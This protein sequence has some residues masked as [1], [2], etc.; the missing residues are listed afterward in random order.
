M[1]ATRD[2]FEGIFPGGTASWGEFAST[3]ALVEVT[4]SAADS[5]TPPGERRILA[6]AKDDVII[7]YVPNNPKVAVI[8]SLGFKCSTWTAEWR[9]PRG[10]RPANKLCPGGTQTQFGIPFS[11][12]NRSQ[13]DQFGACDWVMFLRRPKSSGVGQIA[14][15]P[16]GTFLQVTVQSSADSDATTGLAT[17]QLL[18]QILAGDGTPISTQSSVGL[19][20][21][22]QYGQPTVISDSPQGIYWVVWEAE[23]GDD[24]TTDVFARQVGPDGN[25]IGSAFQV[26]QWVPDSQF[27]PFTLVDT[28]GN[29]TIVWTSMGQDGD[30]GG[31]FARRFQVGGDPS[32]DEFQVNVSSVGDQES[33]QGGVDALGNVTIAWRSGDSEIKARMYSATGIPLTGE[34]AVSSATQGREELVEVDVAAAGG[35]TAHWELYSVDDQFLGRYFRSFDA[36]GNPLGDEAVEAQQ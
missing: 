2:L 34:L 32:G 35:F 25:A 26:N 29:I 8:G 5:T 12:P 13:G 15:G 27:A 7:N 11:C 17:D 24:G 22:V 19:D 10:V 6:G 20:S 28:A 30:Q 31:I 36:A 16:D 21:A 14:V 23:T 18:A 4:S 33:A 1:K 3:A 9:D